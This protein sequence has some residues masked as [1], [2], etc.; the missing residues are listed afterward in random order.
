MTLADICY[1]CALIAHI[2]ASVQ[3][4][5]TREIS[6][7]VWISLIPV[8]ALSI[9]VVLNSSLIV[10]IMY[11]LNVVIG[12]SLAIISSVL[13]L[14]GGADS[15]SIAALSIV[16]PPAEE[17][18]VSSAH[19]VAALPIVSI[20]FNAFLLTL[21]YMTFNA[22]RNLLS[23]RR[24]GS[25]EPRGLK[26][27]ACILFLTY[28][29]VYKIFRKPHAYALA[30]RFTDDGRIVVNLPL[31]VSNEDPRDELIRYLRSDLI[32]IRS[33]VWAV[34]NLPFVAYIT[35]GLAMYCL[36]LSPLER[37]LSALLT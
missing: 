35:A 30:Q 34:Y 7:Y 13:R 10:K 3:D 23:L 17:R 25:C 24:R 8:A 37:I 20:L 1:L 29:P 4:V 5:R 32:T 31:R 33:Y 22:V 15:K 21:C 11:I 18:V 6:D 36:S 26:R 16:L 9:Y 12:C 2:V 14:T 27:V 28:V 19:H